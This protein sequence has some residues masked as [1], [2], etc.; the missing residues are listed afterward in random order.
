MSIASSEWSTQ[1]NEPRQMLSDLT[2]A[3]VT[4]EY[5]AARREVSALNAED[6]GSSYFASLPRRRVDDSINMASESH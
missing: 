2:R 3:Q 6:S 5:I 1:M 4:A